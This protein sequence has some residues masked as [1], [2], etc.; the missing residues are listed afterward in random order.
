MD[1]AVG[2]RTGFGRIRSVTMI[3]AILA[4][5]ILAGEKGVVSVDARMPVM[6][7]LVVL[8]FASLVV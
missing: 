6:F 2:I 7:G 5:R 8:L 3:F 4:G 1:F